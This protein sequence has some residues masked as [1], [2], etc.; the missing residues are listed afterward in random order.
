MKQRGPVA[1]ARLVFFT[2]GFDEQG[3]LDGAADGK[4]AFSA[5]PP[6]CAPRGRRDS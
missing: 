1:I 2:L 3:V 4:P 5:D 6:D